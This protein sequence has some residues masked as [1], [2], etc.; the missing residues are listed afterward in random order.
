MSLNHSLCHNP[1]VVIPSRGVRVPVT[2]DKLHYDF[3]MESAQHSSNLIFKLRVL[4]LNGELIFFVSTWMSAGGVYRVLG[5]R[6]ATTCAGNSAECGPPRAVCRSPCQT[7][8]TWCYFISYASYI[9]HWLTLALSLPLLF[10]HSQTPE[11]CVFI[12]NDNLISIF[13][14]VPLNKTAVSAKL[15]LTHDGIKNKFWTSFR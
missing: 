1:R 11:L 7:V 12:T 14:S 3:V 15:M 9:S 10:K 6:V 2:L 13:S 5:A 4:L 8:P